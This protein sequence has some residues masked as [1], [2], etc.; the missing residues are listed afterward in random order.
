MDGYQ[1]V[2]TE[3]AYADLEEVEAYIG[4]SSRSLGI[5]FTSRIFDKLELLQQQPKMGRKVPEYNKDSIRELLQGKY[6][7][8]YQI[9]DNTVIA[10][11]RVVHG[12]RLLD[13]Q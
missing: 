7:I 1:V 8:V 5:D 9:T 12:S 11:V 4:R 10:V 2:L 13:L 6:K 3:S